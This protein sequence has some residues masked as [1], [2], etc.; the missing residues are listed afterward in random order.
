MFKDG[1]SHWVLSTFNLKANEDGKRG[2]GV[3]VVLVSTCCS[4]NTIIKSVQL[5]NSLKNQIGLVF[6]V[7][8]PK[9]S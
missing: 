9:G 7:F 3:G 6:Q 8:I 2:G 5:F 1:L 4:W